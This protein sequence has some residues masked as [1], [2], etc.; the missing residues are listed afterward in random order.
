MQNKKFK[1]YVH[2]KHTGPLP[3]ATGSPNLIYELEAGSML[4][5][6]TEK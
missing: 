4:E 6:Y 3:K 2:A 5:V 1:W